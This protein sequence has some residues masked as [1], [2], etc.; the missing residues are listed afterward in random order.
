MRKFLGQV[1]LWELENKQERLFE[2]YHLAAY[3]K[4]REY[5]YFG[6]DEFNRKIKYKVLSK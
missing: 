3:L 5:F 6:I 1:N 2:K 4:G